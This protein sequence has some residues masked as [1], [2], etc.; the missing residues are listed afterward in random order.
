MR[1]LVTGGAG[2]I[3]SNIADELVRRGESVRILD[4]LSTGRRSNIGPFEKNIEFIEGDIRSYHIVREAV[5]GMEVILHQAAL[6]S[7]PRSIRDPI[8]TNEVNVVGTLNILAAARDAKV[9]KVVFASSSSIYGDNPVLPKQ[10]DMSPTPLSPYAVSKLAGEKYCSVYARVYGLHTVALRYFNVFGPRQDPTSQYS[11]VIPKFIS[12]IQ[13]DRSPVIYGN[14]EQS[15][16][17]TYVANVIHANLLATSVDCPPGIVL[18]CACHAHISLNDLVK[19]IN[20]IMRKDVKVEY[21]PLR[22][23]DI[24]HSFADISQIKNVLGYTPS[25]LFE[26][27]LKKTIEWYSKGNTVG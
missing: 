26:E 6:P 10:E 8:T 21:A 23:G 4:N 9:K 7:V 1:Y 3:G 11:A 15:R 27:G 5:D 13:N 22:S 25:V 14:G 24:A 2:F 18:N 16:D 20:A 17:F 19:N 12:A